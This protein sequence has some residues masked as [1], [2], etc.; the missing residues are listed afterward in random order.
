M[1]EPS[2]DR[3]SCVFNAE[4]NDQSAQEGNFKSC[5]TKYSKLIEYKNSV[6]EGCGTWLRDEME[7]D[8]G[9]IGEKVDRSSRQYV[10]RLRVNTCISS[11]P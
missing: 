4:N 9:G 7:S 3:L 6:P 5:L 11:R 10:L 2:L 8:F 1:L